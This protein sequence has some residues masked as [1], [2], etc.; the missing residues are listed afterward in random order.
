MKKTVTLD[1]GALAPPLKDQLAIQALRL[2]PDNMDRLQTLI[3]AC[4]TLRLH[5]M[6][7]DGEAHRINKRILKRL[8]SYLVSYVEN[9]G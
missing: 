8:V 7:P 6:I 2:S 5:G 4:I 9:E 3:N 1:I